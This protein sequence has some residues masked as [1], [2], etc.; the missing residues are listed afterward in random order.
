MTVESSPSGFTW[1]KASGSTP[2]EST[3]PDFDHTTLTSEGHYMYTEATEFVP[4]DIAK[5]RLP[6]TPSLTSE[7]KGA[8]CLTFWYHMYGEHIGTLNVTQND[9]I[10]SSLS[11]NQSYDWLQQNITVRFPSE[12]SI[13]FVGVRGGFDIGQPYGDI[14]IDD[15]V[16]YDE[17]CEYEIS[18]EAETTVT[19]TT[20]ITTTEATTSTNPTTILSTLVINETVATPDF[21]FT[22]QSTVSATQSAAT[23]LQFNPTTD[24]QKEV[25]TNFAELSP[26][27]SAA[28][29][30]FVMSKSSNDST[31]ESQT[32][33][34]VNNVTTATQTDTFSTDNM[35]ST[36]AAETNIT[37]YNYN[38]SKPISP[39]AVVITAFNSTMSSNQTD[40]T[41]NSS[42]QMTTVNSRS[43]SAP[44]FTG[45]QS[46]SPSVIETDPQSQGSSRKVWNLTEPNLILILA[47]LSA[48][49]LILLLVICV[50]ACCLCVTRRKYNVARSGNVYNSNT[51]LDSRSGN[52][53][54]RGAARKSYPDYS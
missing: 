17:P 16:I 2:S 43:S 36:T 38:L 27:S 50:L 29:E 32:N 3:G 53:N 8:I 34:T 39:V 1:D 51:T 13:V 23:I 4:G 54:Q 41:S 44:K 25:L 5:L 28:T 26:D 20:T 40:S 24:F 48:F 10:L 18:T 12:G 46:T 35:F 31:V 49:I 6:L 7:P 22:T 42:A 33:S 30:V 9:T 52:D 15:I 21:I 45:W 37:S 19:T 47:F 14:A 11:F